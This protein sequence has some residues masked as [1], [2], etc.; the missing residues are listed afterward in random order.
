MTSTARPAP[1]HV[2]LLGFGA[3]GRQVA[4]QLAPE[5]EA[6]TVR[7]WAAERDVAASRHRALPGVELV[8]TG[9]DL[10]C[11]NWSDV[12]TGADLVVECAG[13]APAGEYGPDV[14]AAGTD[15]VLTSVGALADPDIAR[16]LLAGPGRLWVTSGAIGGFDVL[17]A[18]ADAGGLDRVRIRTTK[19]PTSLLR[20]WMSPAARDALAALRPGDEPV[21]VFSGGPA[22]AIEQFPANVNVAVGLA[23]ATRGRPA[24]GGTET[25]GTETGGTVRGAD[26]VALLRRS[27]DRVRVELVAD[28]AVERS[29]HEILAEG[30]AG[31]FELSFESAP[32]PENP[33]TSGLTALS[34]ARTIREALERRLR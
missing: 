14:I 34:V 1:A 30:P 3:I 16:R 28:P 33:K 25:G 32:S 24:A 6:G 20:P 29:R 10:D 11:L 8:T 18:A 13:V 4:L 31:R 27:L 2:L 7:M 12:L 21:T 5:R 17:G 26:E 15:L 9:A 23:W 19:L 22:Q